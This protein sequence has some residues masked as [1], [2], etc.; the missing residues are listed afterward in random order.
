MKKVFIA[1]MLAVVTLGFSSCGVVNAFIG[2][3][4]MAGAIFAGHTRPVV[5]TSNTVGNKVGTAQ[6]ISVLG[7]AAFGDG[8]IN[9]AAKMAGI[10]K[11]SHVDV[12]V[13]SVLG[14]FTSHKYFVYGE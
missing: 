1:A 2:E 9:K 10:T 14:C 3:P 13:T 12:K 5:A 8:S 7:V 4:T 6:T 11:I